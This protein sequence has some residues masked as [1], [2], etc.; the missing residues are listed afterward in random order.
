MPAGGGK[1]VPR[2]GEWLRARRADLEAQLA[3]HGAILFRGLL[4]DSAEDFDAF[5]RSFDYPNFPYDE[6]LS[7]AVRVNR[8]ER[9]FTANEAPPS[10][11]IRL[12]HELAQTSLHPSQLFFFCEQPAARGGA[13]P[14]CRSDVL[15][16][17][18]NRRCPALVADCE[19]QGLETDAA[20]LPG[21]VHRRAEVV[22]L[23]RGGGV[24]AP[25]S[26]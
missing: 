12:H 9:V 11:T 14:L 6:S 23:R 17:E 16:D 1:P 13:T 8:T 4:L 20:A 15:F 25:A 3:T 7:N 2:A 5:V 19:K 22:A 10:A 21:A 24:R 26:P 18:L